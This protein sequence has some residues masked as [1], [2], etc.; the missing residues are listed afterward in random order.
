MKKGLVFVLLAVFFSSMVS[1][2]AAADTIGG[3][4]APRPGQEAGSGSGSGND[5]SAVEK[6]EVEKVPVYCFYNGY[7]KDHFLTASE[8][9]LNDLLLGYTL[10][11][12]Y[13]MYQGISGHCSQSQA[14][15]SIPVYRFWNGR[16]MDHFYTI[17]EDEKEKLLEDYRFG[18]DNYIYEGIAWY[19]PQT[20][21]TPVY[22]FFDMAGFNHFYTSDEKVKDD[23][24]LAY[25][26]GVGTYKFEG[27]AWYWYD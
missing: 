7:M 1:C 12:S 16:T 5:N 17:N 19:V 20:S 21:D 22:R 3:P 4:Y 25:L 14:E 11:N 2:S 8:D 9:E 18:R 26:N 27:I 24:S 13:Y 10:G 15:D 6:S 23:L